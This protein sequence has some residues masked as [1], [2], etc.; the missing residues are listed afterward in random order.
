MA[1][2]KNSPITDVEKIQ[3]LPWY[4]TGDS[5]N[6][7]FFLLTFSG[8]VFVLY[9]NE[10]QL[11]TAQIGVMLSLIPFVGIIAP[12][13]GPWVARY[14]Y[15]RTFITFW[16]IRNFVFALMLLTPLVLAQFGQEQVFYWVAGIILAFA[17]CRSIAE[18]GGYP[19]RKAA[20]PDT[21]RGKFIAINSMSTTVAG[22][23][24][25]VIAS[26]VIEIGTGLSRFMI[27]MVVGITLGLISV[28]VYSHVP[29]GT[30]KQIGP[31][32]TSHKQAMKQSLKDKNFV[33]FLVT[34]GLVVV[35]S[36]AVISFV[37]LY[38]TDVIGLSEGSVV[39]LSVGTYLGALISSYWWGW[40]ADR[41]GS[42]PIMQFSIILILLLPIGWMLMPRNST[43]S[44]P[45][46]LLIAFV[47]GVATL[48][49][50]ISWVRYLFNN[51]IPSENSAPYSAVYYAWFGFIGGLGPLLIGQML[52][53]STNLEANLWFFQVDSYTPVFILSMVLLTASLFTMSKLTSADATPF[54]RLAG[55]FLRGNPIRALES[56]VQYNFSAS[57]DTR[58][59]ITERMGDAGN[60]LSTY[61]LIEVLNDPSF[62]VRYEAIHSIG[63][64]PPEPE[65]VDALLI[66]LDEGKSEL[67]FVI[68]RSL[69][70]LGDPRAIEPL[71]RLL[72]CGYHLLEANAARALGMLGDNESI[73]HF[74]DKLNYE[75]NPVLKIAYIS[76]LGHLRANQAI[77]QI[78]TVLR[79]T[80]N[81]THRAEI[82]L[83]LA[84]LAGDEKYYMQHWHS[85]RAN[86]AT[87]TAQ[88][89]LA[90]QKQAVST[91]QDTM[92]RQ[93]ESCAA[94]FAQGESNPGASQL[95][96]IT[97]HL[98]QTW[99]NTPQAQILAQCAAGLAEFGESRLEII[100]LSLHTINIILG[101]LQQNKPEYELHSSV[102]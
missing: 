7:G 68:T 87:I 9:L 88:A 23:L 51:A 45:V 22:I 24:V 99:P 92:A 34:L 33:L 62:N 94:K 97:L 49:W 78:F 75:S 74:L 15:K 41:Y 27:L 79:Q 31:A 65:L 53:L 52:R 17:L 98:S 64:M 5:L 48:A 46:A 29:D 67:S 54:R 38:M 56:M 59:A 13:I 8:S 89:L 39:L 63:R 30:Q 47:A 35:G 44:L 57:E 6:T 1:S 50:Q 100:L 90:M 26:Y 21:I 37:P 43:L 11:N 93:I 72:F 55:M 102:H 96:E 42:Q 18:T 16:G 81:E 28:W 12:F 25:T 69:G 84:R 86:P 85:L 66:A 40:T 83:A 32:K 82:G 95:Q 2:Q 4:V 71:R 76:A 77:D 101:E 60:P 3:K 14:G 20:V 70:R 58:I 61:E 80:D 91:K 73:P 10:L 19:W 36:T